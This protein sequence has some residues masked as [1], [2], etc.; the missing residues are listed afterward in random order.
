MTFDN[1][2]TGLSL[3]LIYANA[4]QAVQKA[5]FRCKLLI[6]EECYLS[7]AGGLQRKSK[8]E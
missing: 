2:F 7:T 1:P 4:Q 8:A 6:K 5:V 3:P